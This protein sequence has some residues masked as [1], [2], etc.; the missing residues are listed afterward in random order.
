[1]DKVDMSAFL[2]HFSPSYSTREFDS[3]DVAMV[4]FAKE[5]ERLE[6]A[7]GFLCFSTSRKWILELF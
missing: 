5:L 6:N 7:I 2:K 1:M 3:L 4:Q